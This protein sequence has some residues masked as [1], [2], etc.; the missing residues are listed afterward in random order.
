MKTNSTT[1]FSPYVGLTIALAVGICLADLL[2]IGRLWQVVLLLGL[3][4]SLAVWC[5]RSLLQ[6]LFVLGSVALV[7]FILMTHANK[8]MSKGLPEEAL[9]YECV[10]ASQP[11]VGEKTLRFDL[12]V[13]SSEEPYRIRAT[14]VNDERSRLLKV[15]QGLKVR[16]ELKRPTTEHHGTFDYAR[17]LALHKIVGTTFISQEAWQT[18]PVSLDRLSRLE[19]LK[20]FFLRVRGSLLEHS[21]A[22]LK[23]SEQMAVVAAM[24]LGDK[25]RLSPHTKDV[26]SQ[27]GAS[28]V[29]ALSG[30]HLSILCALFF[31][32]GSGRRRFSFFKV[33]VLVSTVWAFVL[34]VGMPVSVVR[35]AVM[36]TVCSLVGLLRRKS[37]SLNVLA[38]TAFYILLLNPMS[39][40]DVGFQMSFLSV[41]AILMFYKPL[42]GL[43]SFVP[44]YS[45]WKREK[46]WFRLTVDRIWQLTCVSLSAQVGVMPLVAYY[47]HQLPKYFLL[48]NLIV[49]PLAM[50]I[51]YLALLLFITLWTTPV[52]SLIGNVLSSCVQFLNDSLSFVSSLPSS[53]VEHINITPVHVFLFYFIVVIVYALIR[54]FRVG[55]PLVEPAA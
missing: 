27:T 2:S 33:I 39:L 23:T 17:Y 41:A 9:S 51:L 12:L 28:H 7:G 29:L 30:L 25:T 45:R 24:V 16:S 4:L 55:H 48:S 22:L 50:L 14:L 20:L 37:F 1:H 42:Y 19:R 31:V 11:E 5:R 21:E 15:G 54:R 43:L 26:Y 44:F 49:V 35:A 38:I 13:V 46:R 3:M 6:S 34:L 40:F 47:F 8:K 10:I 36:L 32:F 52:S 18:S 53:Q